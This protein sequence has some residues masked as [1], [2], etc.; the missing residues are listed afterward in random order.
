[1]L[2]GKLSGKLENASR[3]ELFASL[4]VRGLRPNKVVVED[5]ELADTPFQT[6]KPGLKVRNKL[7]LNLQICKFENL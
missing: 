1:M 4:S 3:L 5:V 6:Y 2:S 7:T